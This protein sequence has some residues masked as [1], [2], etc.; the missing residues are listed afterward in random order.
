MTHADGS[1]LAKGL[2]AARVLFGLSAAACGAVQEPVDPL[3]RG[4]ENP[5]LNR[6]GSAV[7]FYVGFDG[8]ALAEITSGR[9]EP[10]GNAT[11]TAATKSN[12]VPFEAGVHGQA[13][14]SREYALNYN[15]TGAVLRATGSL[16]IWLKP[17][18]LAHAHSY[19]WPGILDGR[20]GG[21]RIQFGRMGSAGNREALYAHLSHRRDRTTAAMGS[22]RSW[23]TNEWHLMVITWDRHGV[24]FSVDGAS[25]ARS[26]IQLPI[27]GDQAA[28]FHL[29]LLCPSD[30]TF[31]YDE[32]IV[33]NLPLTPAEIRWL[34]EQGQSALKDDTP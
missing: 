4:S 33:F 24:A 12:A 20:S 21:Y 16:A 30:D 31:L 9:P 15:V 3:P 7:V 22:M 28:G 13:L 5:A 14:R 27:A 6:F 23:K 19:F 11:W 26:T 25:P 32:V 18:S 29:N 34:H 1:I 17:L 10:N 8:H 2:R